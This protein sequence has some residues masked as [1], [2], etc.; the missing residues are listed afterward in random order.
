MDKKINTMTR[1]FKII[2]LGCKV[3]QYESAYLKETLA[4]SGWLQALDKEKAD[5]AIINTCI[6]TQRAAHQSRQAI[7]K[8]IRENPHSKIAAIG[9]Y[10]Q[11]YPD[12]LKSIQGIWLI[13]GNTEKGL[14][15]ELLLHDKNLD[16]KSI[17]LNDFKT[18]TPFEFLKIK[19]FPGRTR[20]YLK[21]QDGCR[22][23]CSYCIVPFARGPYRSL[24]PEKVLTMLEIFS[25]Q[26]YKEVVLTGIHLGK[27]GIDLGKDVD[28]T[29]LI[30]EIC[31]EGFPLR[32]RLSSIEPNEINDELVDLVATEKS[33]CR[34]F[35]ISLQNGDDKILKRMKRNYTAGEF[36]KIIKGIYERIPLA[37][38]GVDIISGFPGEDP[39]A[40]KNT[41][42]LIRDLPVSYLHVFPFSPRPLTAAFN[43]DGQVDP[44]VIKK[45]SG[46]LRDLGLR[47]KSEFYHKCLKKEF[48]VLGE[49]W[50]SEEKKTMK[51][52]SDNY[53]PVLFPSPRES[54][55]QLIPV[56]IE[57]VEDNRVTG[58][59]VSS[60][61]AVN[62]SLPVSA[63]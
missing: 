37:A 10:A 31:K 5:L 36:A 18:G 6:V 33:L 61:H 27:Y 8:A 35:H 23:F 51:G 32:I 19:G 16:R 42:S 34:H 43:F 22:S 40:H 7:R 44:R 9:C 54:T 52:R 56:R 41:V 28:L 21:I 20:A 14:L 59:A 17:I 24:V 13:A 48:Q 63:R 46:E 50:H 53:I 2:T 26:E 58:I 11:V 12:E 60:R 29:H 3:N 47:K 49:G 4:Q 57:S 25:R 55:N 62:R 38:I 39:V 45:R 30:R 15:P 1:S